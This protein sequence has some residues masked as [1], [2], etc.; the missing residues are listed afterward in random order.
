MKKIN[1]KKARNSS[2]EQLRKHNKVESKYL[3]D[4]KTKTSSLSTQIGATDYTTGKGYKDMKIQVV[5]Y[6]FANNI[7]FMEG[8][9][10]KYVSRWRAK[11]GIKDLKKAIHFLEMLIELEENEINKK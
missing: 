9:V 11:N 5:E 2:L 4:R 7:P 6:C 8:A 1:Y 3:K 10:I